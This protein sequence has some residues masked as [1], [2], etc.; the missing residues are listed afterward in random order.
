MY[1]ESV[2]TFIRKIQRYRAHVVGP[3]HRNKYLYNI[4]RIIGRY[5]ECEAE[6][7]GVGYFMVIFYIFGFYFIFIFFIFW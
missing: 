5:I 7:R 3:L 4:A 6:D 1:R 2:W